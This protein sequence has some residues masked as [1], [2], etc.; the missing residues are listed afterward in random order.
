MS[1]GDEPVGV[2]GSFDIGSTADQRRVRDM[3]DRLLAAG[4]F[5]DPGGADE[6]LDLAIA[7]RLAR[8][9]A[10]VRDLDWSGRIAVLVAMWGERRRL[11][12]RSETNP[13]GE[14]S[15]AVKLDQLAWLFDGSTVDWSLVAVDD[16]D[17]EDSATVAAERAAGH[18]HGARVAVLRLET[19]IPATGGPLASLGHV[20]DS[21]KG[22][23]MV[24]G[25]VHALD[26]GADA[27][28]V[29]DAD[30]SVNLGQLGLLLE[31]F[32]VGRADAVIGD[33]K[34]PESVL[35][36]AEARWGP[37]I[38]VL[39][40]MQRMVGRELFDR[41][42]SDTQAPFKLYGRAALE[43][44]LAG[45]STFGFSFDADWLYATLAAGLRIERV[46]F[47]FVDSMAESASITQGPMTTWESLLTGLVGAARARGAEH[48]EEMAAVVDDYARAEVLDLV[49]RQV[50][51]PLLGVA[52]EDLGRRETMTPADLRVWLETL[53]P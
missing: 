5:T 49:V 21:R 41:G 25:A 40:H 53:A 1:T 8:S 38:V 29:T 20:D 26:H 27:V 16:G 10:I 42:L 4:R 23:A 22:G 44:I 35:V 52:P 15:L 47:A 48:D 12:P 46:P 6:P 3:A 37:G 24:L 28:V 43:A 17:P 13:T 7:R 31:P 2:T 50:P 36:K 39:R 18:E 11:R 32:A 30:G 45:P 14:D 34:H 9:K 51:E 19:A 33:R